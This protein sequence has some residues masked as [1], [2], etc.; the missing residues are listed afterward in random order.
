MKYRSAG[1]PVIC[2][3]FLPCSTSSSNSV[4]IFFYIPREVIVKHVSDVHNIEAPRSYVSGYKNSNHAV[5]E[6]I[7]GLFPV[8]LLPVQTKS[9]TLLKGPIPFISVVHFTS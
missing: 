3:S 6:F 9:K 5:F 7:K 1:I 4:N 8:V 2:N